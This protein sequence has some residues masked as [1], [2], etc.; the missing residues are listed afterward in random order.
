MKSRDVGVTHEVLGVLHAAAN[1]V[2]DELG[3]PAPPVAPDPAP[4]PP[5][6]APTP[7]IDEGVAVPAYG[8]GW[9]GTF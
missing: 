3:E 2:V 8:V 4:D 7:P 6:P 9:T 1:V 5:A